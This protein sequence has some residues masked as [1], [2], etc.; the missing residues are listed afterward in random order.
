MAVPVSDHLARGFGAQVASVVGE[1]V[2][3][4]LLAT[5]K[6]ESRDE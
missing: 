2:Y 4:A 3:V 6:Y 5:S 1:Q